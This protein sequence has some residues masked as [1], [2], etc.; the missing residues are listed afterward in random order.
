MTQM[1]AEQLGRGDSTR[2]EARIGQTGDD[3]LSSFGAALEALPARP[4]GPQA[5][6]ARLGIDKVL[7][8][9]LLK[10]VRA[11]DSVS[12]VHRMPGPEPLRRVLAG[13]EAQGVPGTV[14]AGARGAVDRFESLIRHEVGDRAALDAIV[15]AWVPEARREF[16]L[17][18]KQAAFRA[19]SQLKGA[20]ARAIMATVMLHPSPDGEHLDVLWLN[21]L[22][23]LQRLRPGAGVKITTRRMSRDRG[24]RM[25]RTLDGA[26]V[27]D[28][29]SLL[30]KD[31]CTAPADGPLPALRV[32]H[33][34]EVVHYSLGGD[35][36]GPGSAIDFV[37]AELSVAELKRYRA[38]GSTRKSYVFAET[39]VPAAIMQF[40][41]LVH[42]DVLSAGRT[43]T[44]RVYDTAFEGVAG[45]N[46]AARDIDI[47]DLNETIE[48]MGTG[49]ARCR[50]ADVPRYAELLRTACMKMGWDES[51][52]RGYRSRIDYPVYGSQVTMLFEAEER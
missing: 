47:L 26:P 52:F 8:S 39:S 44:L 41:A 30:L 21:G 16:E 3:L 2:L 28:L 35:G 49:L 1:Q 12:A 38:T 31:Y 34:D 18:R 4:N 14:I 24:E 9:R 10:A 48:P 43:P 46:D 17:R 33:S 37:F 42:R 45:A 20:E 23:G 29:E 13:L 5:L 22:I 15:S 40:D 51:A 7:A 11:S 50:S 19:M 25:P 27:N 36:F 6:A 32:H